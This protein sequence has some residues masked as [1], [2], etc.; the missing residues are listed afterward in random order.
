MNPLLTKFSR[1]RAIKPR[2]QRIAR[3]TSAARINAM[4]S[5]KEFLASL[6]LRLATELERLASRIHLLEHTIEAER[7]SIP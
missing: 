2:D 7:Q 6:H 1:A 4:E 5:E 3:H